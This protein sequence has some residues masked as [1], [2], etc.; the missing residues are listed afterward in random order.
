MSLDTDKKAIRIAR[1]LTT[2]ADMAPGT[3][4]AI[5][6]ELARLEDKIPR[7]KIDPNAK[8][9]PEERRELQRVI[10]ATL[11]INAKTME[12]TRL[13]ETLDAIFERFDVALKKVD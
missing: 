7:P 3:A 10:L 9:K 1:R 4:H 11:R 12:F 8:G 2:R 13:T 5:A 6:L